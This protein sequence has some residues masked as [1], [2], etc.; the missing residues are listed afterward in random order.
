MLWWYYC[1]SNLTIKVTFLFLE[2]KNIY[3][4]AWLRIVAQSK[5]NYEILYSTKFLKY[6]N[7]QIIKW[8]FWSQLCL[9]KVILNYLF[10]AYLIKNFIN[11]NF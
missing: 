7:Y 5:A 8:L 4:N 2:I 3:W 1:Y 9:K 11:L 6:T 10:K